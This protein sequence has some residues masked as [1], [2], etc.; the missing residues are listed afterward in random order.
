MMCAH[1][2]VNLCKPEEQQH[3]LFVVSIATSST[4]LKLFE[5]EVQLLLIESLCQLRKHIEHVD[6]HSLKGIRLHDTATNVSQFSA[7]GAQCILALDD[8]RHSDHA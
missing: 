3:A 2:C 4:G 7:L 1:L 5:Q 8:L 6:P